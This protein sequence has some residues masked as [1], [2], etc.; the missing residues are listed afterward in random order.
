MYRDG[1]SLNI[2]LGRVLKK[3][4]FRC[5]IYYLKLSEVNED[6]E[7]LDM[8]FEWVIKTG[9][10]VAEIKK[11]M[12][13]KYALNANLD[14]NNIDMNKFRIRKKNTKNPGKIYLDDQFFGDDIALT[15]YSE[16]SYLQIQQCI[17][18]TL[19]FLQFILQELEGE[20]IIPTDPDDIVLFVRRW[21][22]ST[23]T[24]GKFEELL[25]TSKFHIF[26]RLCFG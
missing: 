20:P 2:E 13:K 15:A 16:V 10:N 9:D 4:E 8:L 26:K 19:L 25:V 23:L 21:S 22:P 24:L 11:A 3:G 17:Y 7:Q 12:V 14:I 5:K 6:A 18:K 1:D